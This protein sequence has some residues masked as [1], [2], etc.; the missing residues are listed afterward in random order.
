MAQLQA[1]VC[2][3]VITPP[4]YVGRG[5]STALKMSIG[6]YHMIDK[7]VVIDNVVLLIG[8]YRR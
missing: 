5:V 8:L 2:V 3:P 7:K 1:A 6:S 4:A